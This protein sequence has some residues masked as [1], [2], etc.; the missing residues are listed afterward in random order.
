VRTVK[1]DRWA[2]AVNN[3]SEVVK[4][5]SFN[6]GST[7]GANL[8]GEWSTG[9][10]ISRSGPRPSKFLVPHES[11]VLTLTVF[12]LHNR[13]QGRESNHFCA[14]HRPTSADKLLGQAVIWVFCGAR[15]DYP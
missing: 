11:I 2:I 14:P 4:K 12:L 15:T 7:I 9:S 8:W 10:L 6:I 3:S 1:T 5:L 13:H